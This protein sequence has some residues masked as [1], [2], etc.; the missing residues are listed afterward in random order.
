MQQLI[1]VVMMVLFIGCNKDEVSFIN[2]ENNINNT[3]ILTT[4]ERE[5]AKSH[6]ENAKKYNYKLITTIDL[7]HKL[8][9]NENIEIIA[10]VPI[11]LY[12]LGFIKGAKNFE[13]N[14]EFSGIWEEDTKNPKEKFL[15]F[16]GNK[17]KEIIFYDNGE[18]NAI[19]ATIWAKNLGYQNVSILIGGFIGWR[20]R[21]FEISFDMPECCRI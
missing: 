16:L 12:T 5:I 3:Q 15:E 18:T 14:S 21:N 13:F 1:F 10:V 6:I 20:E 11:G 9:N 4:K 19:T 7:K 2:I 17:D 8:D